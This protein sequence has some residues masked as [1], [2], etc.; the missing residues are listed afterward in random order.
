MNPQLCISDEIQLNYLHWL[1]A[2][3]QGDLV[4]L[5]I[6]ERLTDLFWVRFTQTFQSRFACGRP[7]EFP[8]GNIP[9]RTEN[10]VFLTILYRF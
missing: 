10:N 4:R 9:Y 7:L 1:H 3:F 6:L 5:Q 2:I 8:H